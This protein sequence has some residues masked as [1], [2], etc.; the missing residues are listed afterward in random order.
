MAVVASGEKRPGSL[1]R[2]A[3]WLRSSVVWR[4]GFGELHEWFSLAVLLL[5]LSIAVWSIERAAWIEPQP[6]LLAALVVAV[7]AGQTAVRTRWRTPLVYAVMVVLG[8]AVVVWQTVGLFVT[9]EVESAFALWWDAVSSDRPSEGTTYFAMFLVFITWVVGFAATVFVLRRRNA[10]PAVALGSLMVLVNLSNLPKDDHVLLP[11]YWLTALL[12]VGQVNLAQQGAWFGRHGAS[13]SYRG[14]AYLVGAVVSISLVSVLA[15]WLVPEPPV[16]R[17]QLAA[18]GGSG[19]SGDSWYNIFADVHAKWSVIDS[20]WQSEMSF[21]DSLS[22]SPRV[23]FIVTA[24]QPAYWRTRRYDIYQAWGWTSDGTVEHESSDLLPL[25]VDIST[26][27]YSVEN[28]LKTDVVLTLGDFV[29]ASLPFEI[30]A[31]GRDGDQTGEVDGPAPDADK[32]VVV[33]EREAAIVSDGVTAGEPSP[34]AAGDVIAVVTPRPM[35]PYQR[36][37]ATALVNLPTAEELSEAGN[38]YPQAVLDRYL[39]LPPELPWR[40]R[41]LAANLTWDAE[42]AYDKVLAIKEHVLQLT[43]NLESGPIPDGA[44]AVDYFLFDSRE[45]V[46]TEFASALA[47]MLRTTGIPSR[48]TTG[49]LEGDFDE[50]TGSYFLRTRDYHARTEVYFP[51]YGWVEFSATPVGE[52][53]GTVVGA[54]I[55]DPDESID[56]ALLSMTDDPFGPGS[57]L[58]VAEG[59]TPARRSWGGP[60]LYVYLVVIGTPVA[61]LLVAR[62]VYFLWLRALKRADSPAEIYDRMCRLASWGRAGPMVQETPL[63][64]SSRLALAL[65]LQAASIDTIVEAYVEIRFSTRRELGQLHKGRL[66]K[67]WVR[68]VPDLARGLPRLW[69][70]S[71]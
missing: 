34:V 37:T 21:S 61:L 27:A 55:E 15:A 18:F 1:S 41:L 12:L 23:Q 42:T 13:Y 53:V 24:D 38:D 30:V 25:P 47:V 62:F 54:T 16:E 49:Y 11:L 19:E 4:A 59:S 50:D 58:V 65:P 57:E 52:N 7:L 5:S 6:S 68:L 22:I 20:E 48:F 66:Q 45:G 70:E 39:Q 43:Y 60:Q 10:W 9:P 14:V 35:K 44:D 46:C 71:A 51:S 56:P 69:R 32:T 40:V 17:I 8:L 29:S 28:R 36:Y 67:A 64:Y 33:A 3:R 2:L 31:F 63:E 26:I